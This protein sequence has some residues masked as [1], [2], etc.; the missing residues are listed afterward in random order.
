MATATRI[1]MA[2]FNFA[3]CPKPLQSDF[4]EL[5]RCA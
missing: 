2:R 5:V 1:F 3:G 4:D